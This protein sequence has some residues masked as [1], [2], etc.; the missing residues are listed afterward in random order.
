MVRLVV[1]EAGERRAFK[2]GR[3]RVTIGSGEGA[4]L[5]LASPGVADVHAELEVDGDDVRL[6]PRPGVLPPEMAGRKLSGPAKLRHGMAVTIGDARLFVELEGQPGTGEGAAERPVAPVRTSN[7]SAGRRRRAGR[8]RGNPV[9][10]LGITLG[11]VV[12]LAIVAWKIAF[13]V[14]FAQDSAGIFQPALIVQKAEQYVEDARWDLAEGELDRLPVGDELPEST[15]R[16]VAQLREAIEDGRA[17]NELHWHNQTGT[18]YFTT[19]LERFESSRL[20]GQPERPKVR[21]FLERCRFFRETW[22]EHPKL[23]WVRRQESRFAGVVSLSDPMTLDDLAFKVESLT[24]AEPRQFGEA[25]ATIDAFLDDAGPSEA[26]TAEGLRAETVQRRDEWVD[27]RLQQARYEFERGDVAKSAAVLRALIV[28]SGDEAV[29]D[30]AAARLVAFDDFEAIARGYR[31]HDPR[32][33]DEMMEHPT[34]RAKALEL[35][36]LE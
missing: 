36:V 7:T 5:K 26:E 25:L 11:V 6:V 14:F 33:F 4:K 27:D 21:V 34:V 18:E 12:V 17:A 32:R 2:I 23:D 9:A 29:A 35:G 31:R 10:S 19:Q 15:R 3:G 22:P 16:R 24:W 20:Q 28:H 13:P 1:E 30:D 8:K